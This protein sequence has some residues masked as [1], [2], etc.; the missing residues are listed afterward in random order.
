M[1]EHEHEWVPQ[2]DSHGALMGYWCGV[3][4]AYK[5]N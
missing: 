1:A 5:P 2:Y 3:C 4:G